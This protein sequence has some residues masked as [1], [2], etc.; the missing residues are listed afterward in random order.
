MNKI[1]FLV[2][3][4]FLLSCSAFSEKESST[5]LAQTNE[6][7]TTVDRVHLMCRKKR[8]ASAVKLIDKWIVEKAENPYSKQMLGYQKNIKVASESWGVVVSS[9]QK[10]DGATFK[11]KG[12]SYTAKAV[13][14]D[15]VMAEYNGRLKSFL[16]TS[17][18]INSFYPILKKVTPKNYKNSYIRL[19]ASQGVSNFSLYKM[20]SRQADADL[21]EWVGFCYQLNIL[22]S[23]CVKLKDVERQLSAERF[24][25]AE[26]GLK[27]ILSKKRSYSAIKSLY[28]A[29]VKRLSEII[30]SAF[31]ESEHIK[32]ERFVNFPIK[33]GKSGRI[34]TLDYP[35]VKYDI[36]LPSGYSPDE[37]KLLPIL[38]TFSPGGGGMM[39]QFQ[40]VGEELQMIVIGDL[41]SKNLR[42]DDLRVHSYY[43]VIADVRKRVKFD[44]TAQFASGMSG[45]G[46]VSFDYAMYHSSQISGVFSMGGWLGYDV[47]CCKYLDGLIVTR[48]NGDNDKGANSYIQRDKD[49]L[50]K[51][52]VKLK[53]WFFKGG[54]VVSPDSVKKEALA[55]MLSERKQE[56]EGDRTSAEK[57]VV[58]WKKLIGSGKVND[59][60]NL[61]YTTLLSKPRTHQSLQAQLLLEE[62]FPRILEK[63]VKIK[64]DYNA[65][66]A[67]YF[68]LLGHGAGILK[69]SVGFY[70]A[71]KCL[72]SM[73]CPIEDFYGGLVWFLS[74][75]DDEKIKN[76]ELA[77]KLT[78]S[79]EE[80]KGFEKDLYTKITAAAT[81]KA[82]GNSGVSQKLLEE[83]CAKV[84]AHRYRIVQNYND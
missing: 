39:R 84:D 71:L 18:P 57:L 49:H 45:G 9:G 25:E 33:P 10:V 16:L 4:L 56:E 62:T 37:D 38:Y 52:N 81:Y 58:D 80:S 51:Y 35:T 15:K 67:E 27:Q 28:T 22:K 65:Q 70:S 75:S 42:P 60:L 19:S 68:K 36:Y 41:H 44:P 53:D 12:V 17:L 26:Y 66:L 64:L 83:G 1:V 32:G 73:D 48:G 69:D 14:G 72:Q 54:H 20:L 29:E 63:E 6:Y 8:F 11:V 40:K 82:S 78:K 34:P 23:F 2:S 76:L 5:L 77:M 46:L 43:A 61:C 74:M 59:A 7:V 3:S 13:I 55:W 21:R 31:D 50:Q 47:N 30:K 24:I 79:V